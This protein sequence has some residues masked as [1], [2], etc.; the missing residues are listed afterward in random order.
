MSESRISLKTSEVIGGAAA[1]VAAMQAGSRVHAEGGDLIKIGLVGCGGR[2]RGALINALSNTATQNLKVTAIAD[3]FEQPV[4][5]TEKLCRSEKPDF[6]S[7]PEEQMYWGIEAGKDLIEKSNVDVVLLCEPPGIRTRNLLLAAKAGKHIFAEK[8]VATD[9]VGVRIALEAAEIAE[10]KGKILIVGHHLR[11]EDKHIEPIKMLHDGA[12]GDLVCMRIYFNDAGVWTRPKQAGETEMQHQ[13]KNWY[14]FNWLSGDHI[15]EQH[16]HDI[17]VMNWMAKDQHPIRANGMGGRQVRISPNHGEIYDHHT[18][19]FI[20]DDEVRGLSYCR[21]I[22][23]CWNSFSEH[24]IGTKGTLDIEGHGRSVL[25]INGKEPQVWRRTYDGHQKEMNVL[26]DAIV[27]GKKLNAGKQGAIASMT[28]I[29]GRLATYSGVEIS[30]D[31]A[32]KSTLDLFPK[33]LTWDADIA[34]KPGTDG[35][36]PCAIPGAINLADWGM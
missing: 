5:A 25:K 1:G 23:N 36:Y 12:I 21:H 14:Y 6:F 7:V 11:Y 26:F 30:W 22:P 27:N 19:E 3:A 31:A 17:D 20:F 2:G 28:A 33:K 9:P 8:P 29:L 16:V 32:F 18:V 13:L 35:L 34:P 15:C 4:R 10:Q 24:A